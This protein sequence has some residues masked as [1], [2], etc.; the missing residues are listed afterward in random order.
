MVVVSKLVDDL[1]RDYGYVVLVGVSGGFL[2]MWLS[3]NVGRARK[4][5]GVP[6]SSSGFLKINYYIY[7][8]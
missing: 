4:Q 2:N 1:P 6:V 5:Y 3:G 8:W 7:I